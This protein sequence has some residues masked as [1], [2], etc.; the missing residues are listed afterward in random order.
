M[1]LGGRW[2]L[3]LVEK[4]LKYLVFFLLNDQKN[5]PFVIRQLLLIVFPKDNLYQDAK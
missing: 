4:G 2:R 1:L 3:P 5:Y